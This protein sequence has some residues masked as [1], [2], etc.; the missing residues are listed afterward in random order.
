MSITCDISVFYLTSLPIF[1][2]LIMLLLLIIKNFKS[3][4]LSAEYDLDSLQI[5]AEF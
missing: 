5:V 1:W 2:E 3:Y 4:L